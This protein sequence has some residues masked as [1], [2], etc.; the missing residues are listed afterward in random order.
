MRG[1]RKKRNIRTHLT[2]RD[3]RVQISAE[4]GRENQTVETMGECDM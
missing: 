2:Q 3:G 1:T 4:P